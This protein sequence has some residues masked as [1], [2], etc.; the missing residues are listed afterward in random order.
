MTY[1]M[2]N[3]K[4]RFSTVDEYIALQA[5]ATQLFLE[6][7]RQTI[8]DAAPDAEELI[9]YQMPAY[10]F[11]GQF[12]WFAAYK[13]H[14]GLYVLKKVVAAFAEKLKPYKSGAATIQ[15]TYDAPFPKELVR[16]I[17]EYAVKVNQDAAVLKKAAKS[18]E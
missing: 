4:I 1:T 3:E 15:F 14:Y 12:V 7:L 11:H 8:R 10:R 2:E 17:I 9:S 5:E 13:N 16:E 18:K 6:E